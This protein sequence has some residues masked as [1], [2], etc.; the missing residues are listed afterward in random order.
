MIVT[1]TERLILRQWRDEDIEPFVRM[2]ADPNVMQYFPSLYSADQTRALVERVRNDIDRNGWG[3]WAAQRKD[4]S[5]FIGFIG[6]NQVNEGLAFAPC[7]DI[8]WRLAKEHWG[9]GFA[10]EG[11]LASLAYGFDQAGM[12]EIV[13]IT[14]TTNQPSERVMQ[15][16]GMRKAARNFMHPEVPKSDPLCEH[17]LYRLTSSQ[18]LANR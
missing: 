1:E 4:T 17:V 7:V 5:E 13:S 6:I 11:A 14:P 2:N 8:G 3:F 18:W 10:T 9:V 12:D 16:I 15:K